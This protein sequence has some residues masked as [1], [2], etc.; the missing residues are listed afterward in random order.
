MRGPQAVGCVMGTASKVHTK[1]ALLHILP[2]HSHGDI[3]GAG[4]REA[5]ASPPSHYLSAFPPPAL[6]LLRHSLSLL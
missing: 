4:P 1:R 2:P 3:I 6:P 5:A